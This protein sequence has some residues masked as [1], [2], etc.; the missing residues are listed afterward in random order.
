MATPYF[1]NRPEQITGQSFRQ[2]AEAYAPEVIMPYAEALGSV[3]QAQVQGP[4]GVTYGR[5]LAR[6]GDARNQI[7]AGLGS[8]LASLDINRGL[9]ER[10]A[11]DAQRSQAINWEAQNAAR[12][13]AAAAEAGKHFGNIPSQLVSLLSQGD[14][15]VVEGGQ[16]PR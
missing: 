3:K 6:M 1:F 16:V 12:D 7:A 5:Q 10:A 4:G 8:Q 2:Q 14:A 15:A 11:R 13:A 9:Q